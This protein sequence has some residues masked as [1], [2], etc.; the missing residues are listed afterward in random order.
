MSFTEVGSELGKLWKDMSKKAK[1]PF[2]EKAE[3]DKE[4]YTKAMESY[5]P[6][7]DIVEKNAKQAV[8]RLKK[9]PAKPKRSRSAYLVFCD[10]H[11]P[12]L[13][14]EH[15]EKSMIELATLLAAQWKTVGSKEKDKCETI[16]A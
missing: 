12:E 3:I 4:R 1:K 8:K 11:R 5:V 2:N 9:D 15:S 13:Q 6:D 10:R 14:K 16:A 7:P